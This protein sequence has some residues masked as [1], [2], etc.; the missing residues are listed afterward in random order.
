MDESTIG[1]AGPVASP[2]LSRAYQSSWDATQPRRAIGL[3]AAAP[4]KAEV[5]GVIV[6]DHKIVA[7]IVAAFTL[8]TMGSA[9]PVGAS[10][11]D[12]REILKKMDELY[13]AESS[14]SEVVMEIVTPRW[15]RTLE[16]TVWTEREDKTFIRIHTP[17]KEEGM[18][19]LR[20]GN[21]MWNYLP[22]TNKVMK[23]PPS[24]MMGSWMGSD[25]TN[26]DIVNEITYLDDYTYDWTTVDSPEEGVLY[27]TLT[28]KEDVP[29]VWGHLVMAVREADL[30]PVW[31]RYYDEK[32][33]PMRTMTFTDVRQFGSRTLPSTMEVVPAKKEGHRTTVRYTEARFDVPLEEGIFTLRNLR[34]PR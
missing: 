7:K 29:V 22:K 17:R 5:K 15:E 4:N 19:T 18:G 30:L 11:K 8:L 16:M 9:I 23:I 26:D 13:R 33:R 2:S 32:N 34:S 6:V 20:I 1:A 12:I 31:E 25:F 14:Y 24:M 21:E 27:I 28:P 3:W 10:E